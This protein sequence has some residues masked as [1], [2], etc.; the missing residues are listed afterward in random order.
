M[1]NKVILC[2]LLTLT[3]LPVLTACGGRS[4]EPL[5]IDCEAL[6]EQL[7]ALPDLPGMVPVSERRIRNYY[8]IDT[9]ACPQVVMA[10]C[11][12]ELRADEIWLIEAASEEAAQELA[13]LAEARI[14][15]LKAEL[16]NYQPEQEAMVKK[17]QV[18][19]KGTNIALFI[20]PRAEEMAALYRKAL[21]G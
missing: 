3:L 14:T 12:D 2:L 9:D 19:Q 10:V 4:A 20:S 13:Q 16:K 17:G 6:Y 11:E 8:G 1:K 5:H 18:L 15:Q 21:G 7:L